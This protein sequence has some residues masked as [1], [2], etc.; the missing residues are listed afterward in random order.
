MLRGRAPAERV[1]R[2]LRQ[3]VNAYFT[4]MRLGPLTMVDAT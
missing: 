4:G 3:R 1:A 2:A